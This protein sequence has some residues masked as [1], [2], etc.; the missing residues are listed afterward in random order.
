MKKTICSALFLFAGSCDALWGYTKVPTQDNCL[1][2][3][4]VCQPYEICN[5]NT[6][7]C[8]QQQPQLNAVKPQVIFFDGGD[9]ISING[10]L[11]YTSCMPVYQRDSYW[12]CPWVE[13]LGGLSRR[14]VVLASRGSE[15]RHV[16]RNRIQSVQSSCMQ[17]GS[18][19]SW[20]ETSQLPIRRC[21]SPTA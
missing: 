13:Y 6:E 5:A 21:R 8:E 12:F 19:N 4:L 20:Q 7:Q 16:H 18:P 2:G 11:L 10:C 14:L 15:M 1:A 9:R 17:P 3:G